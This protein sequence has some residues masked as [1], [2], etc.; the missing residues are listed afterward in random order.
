MTKTILRVSPIR[1]IGAK[2]RPHATPWMPLYCVDLVLAKKKKKKKKSG[3]ALRHPQT[4]VYGPGQRNGRLQA[5][6]VAGQAGQL[7]E[8]QPEVITFDPPADLQPALVMPWD[9]RRPWLPR[10]SSSTGDAPA[11]GAQVAEAAAHVPPP[12][13]LVDD[14]RAAVIDPRTWGLGARP[15]HEYIVKEGTARQL[16]LRRIQDRDDRNPH[17]ALRPTIWADAPDDPRSGLR[18]LEP[19]WLSSQGGSAAAAGGEPLVRRDAHSGARPT[20][21]L[22]RPWMHPAPSR[23]PPKRV[24]LASG[25]AAA[26]V[27]P[28]PPPE[29]LPSDSQDLAA[30]QPAPEVPWSQAWRVVSYR[31]LD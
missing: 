14:W 13:Y 11:D 2:V 28:P 23:P 30:R 8:V 20:R 31:D 1:Y 19:R 29:P 27:P 3:L 10:H 21:P 9:P 5:A 22:M 26:P 24:R 7:T 15:A 4:G 17:G 16:L 12:L 25:A 6:H 18:V